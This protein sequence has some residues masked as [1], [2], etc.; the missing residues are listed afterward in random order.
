MT[1]PLLTELDLR[2]MRDALEHTRSQCSPEDHA[3]L[4][5]MVE[6]LAEVMAMVRESNA[7]DDTPVGE[8][9]LAQA[10]E[11]VRARRSR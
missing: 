2:A 11:R 7:D 4:T 1:K 9:F 6:V 8:E 5:D 10:I 3:R